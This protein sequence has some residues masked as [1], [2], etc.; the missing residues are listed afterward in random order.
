M[1]VAGMHRSGTSMIAR[2]LQVS[3]LY[4][5]EAR[6]F[7]APM[8][9]NVEG[10]WEHEEFLRLNNDLLGYLGGGWDYPPIHPLDITDR[11]LDLFRKRA[12][13][14]ISSFDGHPVW[15]WKDPRTS[16]LMPFWR[17]CIEDL[18]TVILLRNPIEVAQ[19]LAKR[20][21]SSAAFV[22]SLWKQYYAALLRDCP[23]DQRLVVSYD[24]CMQNPRRE[25][26]RVLHF[27]NL[28]VPPS[29]RSAAAALPRRSLR[30]S[31]HGIE[32]LLEMG[33]DSEI[34]H[35]FEQ[36]RIESALGIGSEKEAISTLNTERDDERARGIT[37][38]LPDDRSWWRRNIEHP[39][40]QMVL[41]LVGAEW[42]IQSQEEELRDL[43][44]QIAER[45]HWEQQ[46]QSKRD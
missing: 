40:R 36:L 31:S 3:G 39:A 43:R 46:L 30:H 32:D 28:P 19:S 8:S 7:S 21:A 16:L 41:R 24:A 22:L 4:L 23:R 45:V 44:L 34:P 26:E 38:G 2:M 37:V 12:A 11:G 17:S 14:L 29:R 42:V 35:I 25:L 13:E 5:G 18:K 20:N 33:I 15:G 10:H 9:S 27:I 6:F 1:C